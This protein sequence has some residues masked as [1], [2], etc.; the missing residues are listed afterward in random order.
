MSIDGDNRHRLPVKHQAAALSNILVEIDRLNRVMRSAMESA[1]GDE[2]IEILKDLKQITDMR[3][4]NVTAA[5]TLIV[6]LGLSM[7]TTGERANRTQRLRAE[8][9]VAMPVDDFG[10]V[11]P[12]N[13]G[14]WADMVK[15]LRA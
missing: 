11:T 14:N 15:N 10:A 2:L 8:K 3:N 9:K 5:T 12:G 4:K 7:A 13:N 6:K 1:E